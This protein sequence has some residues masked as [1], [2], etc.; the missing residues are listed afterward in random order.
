MVVGY[1]RGLARALERLEIPSFLWGNC[2]ARAAQ[3]FLDV[4][5]APIPT[6]RKE[7]E[8][9]AREFLG[10]EPI[11]HVIAGTEEAVYAASV[12]RRVLKARKSR[13][14]VVLKCQ[15]KVL[16]KTFLSKAQIPMTPFIPYSRNLSPMTAL[17]KLGSPVVVK[18]RRSSGGR[19]LQFAWTSAEVKRYLRPHTLMEKYV[20]APEGSVESFVQ[21][22]QV[23]FTNVTQ[24]LVKKHINLVPAHYAPSLIRALEELNRNVIAAL[25]IQ[26]GLTHM[27]FYLTEHGPLFG[28]IALRP[29]GGYLMPLMARAYGFDPWEAFVKIET[30]QEVDFPK[31]NLR[32]TSAEV[33]HPGSGRVVHVEGQAAV[34]GMAQTRKFHLKVQGGDSITERVGVGEEVGHILL[35]DETPE[36]LRNAIARVRDEFHIEVDR[37]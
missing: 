9:T 33:I 8:H 1:R 16:M 4:L 36:G 14:T 24:Y 5:D 23:R 6:S 25:N 10:R 37:S 3:R 27:E 2:S 29:P 15:D 22:G 20:D 32:W 17:E 7:I 13:D 30:E 11:T 26:W 18:E 19:G 28:E 35:E 12:I 31:K 34:E 21:N